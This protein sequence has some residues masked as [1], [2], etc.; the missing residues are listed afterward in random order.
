MSDVDLA[1]LGGGPAGYAA[2]L[3]AV[4]R[5]M[6][7][8]IVEADAVG[9]TCLH[10]GCIPSKAMLH[11]GELMDEA[12]AAGAW[13]IDVRLQSVDPVAM[14]ARRDR[15]VRTLHA[16][17]RSLLRTRGVGVVEARGR[18]ADDGRTILAGEE[19]IRGRAVMLATGSRPRRLDVAVV[20][21]RL[22]LSSDEA[23]RLGRVPR[24]A[25]VIGSGAV[26]LEFASMW[27]SLGAEEVTL[28][29]V[30]DRLAPAED[31]EVSRVL[32]AALERRGVRVLTGTSVARLDAGGEVARVELAVEAPAIEADTVLVATGREPA[33]DDCGLEALGV[34]DDGGFVRCDA[35]GRTPADGVFAAGD[36]RPA[37]SPMLAHGAFAEGFVVADTV[38]G[39]AVVPVD[40]VLVPRVTYA[41]PEVASVGLTEAAAAAAG[42]EP[43]A[44]VVGL[45]GNARALI[46]DG[47]EGMVKTVVAGDGRVV[48]VHMVGPRVTELAA[49]AQQVTGWEALT[50]EVAA[51]VAPH[52]T[53]SEALGE[54]H[55]AAAGLPFHVHP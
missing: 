36:L 37:P 44:T 16:G 38:A 50:A 12:R 47:G 24:R 48:G 29:E 6:S 42:M 19:R 13:G 1:V 45:R 10:R 7:A 15:I 43:S 21:G 11:A 54:V 40:P 52:P 2:A 35:W 9:G 17:L 34:L 27:R 14:A 32:T 26:G 33:T 5:G 4:A 20:D 51:L 30:L 41:T 23:T 49:Q 53:L 46:L 22:V 8:T 31:E 18:V 3:R 25:V 39:V 28:I 55:L